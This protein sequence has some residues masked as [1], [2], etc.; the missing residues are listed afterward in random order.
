MITPRRPSIY[1]TQWVIVDSKHLDFVVDRSGTADVTN[2][3]LSKVPDPSQ[4]LIRVSDLVE[5]D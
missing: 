5:I 2:K 1:Q 3:Y 4:V